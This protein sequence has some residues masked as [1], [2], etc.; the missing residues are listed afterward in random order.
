MYYISTLSI[1]IPLP[2]RRNQTLDRDYWYRR[3]K[4]VGQ[5]AR[6]Q[7]SAKFK[8]ILTRD[9]CLNTFYFLTGVLS[10]T[11]GGTRLQEVPIVF[12]VRS[13]VECV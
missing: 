7:G 6:G 2:T 8:R 9:P 1:E 13:A 3:R 10:R 12:T 5:G 11:S 4:A